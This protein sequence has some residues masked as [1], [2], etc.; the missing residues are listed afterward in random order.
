MSVCCQ[1]I[2]IVT[3]IVFSQVTAVGLADEQAQP[4]HVLTNS[5]DMKLVE[6]SMGEFLMGSPEGD[7]SANEDEKPQHGVT[8]TNPFFMGIYEVTQNEYERVMEA[9]PSYFS[10][11]GRSKGKVA[12]LDTRRFPVEYVRWKEAMEFCGK[13]SELPQEKSAGRVYRLPTEA[14]WEFAC[15]AGTTTAFHFDNLLSSA[16]ANFNGMLPSPGVPTGPFLGRPTTVGSYKPNALGLYDMHGNVWEWCSDW[17]RA[18]YYKDSPSVD[19]PGAASSSDAS[20]RGGSWA[21]DALNCR[22]AYRYNVLPVH[23]F[24]TRGF[25]VVMTITE[26]NEVATAPAEQTETEKPLSQEATEREQVFQTIVQPFL[27]NFCFECH[28]GDSPQSGLALNTFQHASELATTGRK[29]WMAVR[30]QL[31][32]RGMPPQDAQQPSHDD[33]QMLTSWIQDAIAAVDCSGEPDPGNET[34]RRLN[35]AEYRNTIRDLLGIDYPD[36]DDFPTDD[37]GAGGDALS[38][39]PVLMERYLIAAEEIADRVIVTDAKQADKTESLRG[40]IFIQPGPQVSRHH[41][42]RMVLTRL[43]SRAYRR[44]VTDVEIE[45]LLRLVDTTHEQGGSFKESIH[46]A[47]RAILVSPNFLFRVE[48]DPPSVDPEAIRELSEDELATRMS[49]FMWSSMPDDELLE[50]SRQQTLRTNL[51]DQVRRMLDDPR[52]RALGT[53][54]GGHWLQLSRLKS[55]QPD[56]SVFP[57]FDDNLRGAM[58]TETQMFVNTIISENRSMLDLL[59]AD[60]TFVNERL[61]KHYGLEHVEGAG[62]QRVSLQNNLRGG[63]LTHG[64]VLALTS[65]PTRTSPVKR[66]KW[67]M[68]TILGTPPPAPPPGASEFEKTNKTA[69]SGSFRERMSQHVSNP[70]CAVCH[71]QMDSLGFSLENFDGIGRWRTHDGK[72]PIDT[73]GELPDGQRI[74]GPAELRE[75]L[76]NSRKDKFIKCLTEKLLAYALGR[77][78]EYYDVCA[79]DKIQKVL[80]TDNYRFSTLVTQVI[81]SEPFQKRRGKR[82][83]NSW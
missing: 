17:Y 40:I 70:R 48:S 13:L 21:D 8:I 26:N 75:I 52:S 80:S 66:G 60:F 49:Y 33:V 78:L 10:K 55:I 51:D 1:F 45:R 34:I 4:T 25:R 83:I 57:E 2:S 77:E 56:A 23:R 47:L 19:P 58:W 59:T 24:Q 42:A 31:L 63:V 72:F 7:I 65:N 41:A 35:R 6:I 81:K 37:I 71:K 22:S 14:E 9:N 18:D 38:I 62:F 67:I 46:L 28:S 69:T 16:Q 39:A 43:A 30:N 82:K 53:D 54:F 3:L 5:I 79:T 50:Q 44:P 61:A 11:T 20:V 73:S 29:A 76:S 64:S 27:K 74:N 15:R 12:G 32:A 36:A 68:E